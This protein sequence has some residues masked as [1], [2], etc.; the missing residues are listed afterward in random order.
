MRELD[1]DP[2]SGF[3]PMICNSWKIGMTPD[4]KT[5]TW[6]RLDSNQPVDHTIWFVGW[7]SSSCFEARLQRQGRGASNSL[8]SGIGMYLDHP[9]TDVEIAGL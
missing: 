2:L 3:V 7:A 9:F 6:Q 4:D 8:E 1:I 5:R